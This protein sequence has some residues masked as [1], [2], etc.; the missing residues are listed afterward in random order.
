MFENIMEDNTLAPLFLKNS[1]RCVSVG[2]TLRNANQ[3]A[4]TI[5]KTR[6]FLSGDFRKGVGEGCP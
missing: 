6:A 2:G 3:R 4:L 5:G 1:R